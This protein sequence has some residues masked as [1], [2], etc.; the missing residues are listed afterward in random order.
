MIPA[1]IVIA[2]SVSGVSQEGRGMRPR[3]EPGSAGSP[4]STTMGSAT[5][6]GAPVAAWPGAPAKAGPPG[7]VSGVRVSR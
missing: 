4:G 2:P 3:V 7:T 6:G 5:V 1:T